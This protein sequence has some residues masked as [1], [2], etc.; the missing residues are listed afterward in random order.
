[1]L[2]SYKWAQRCA[3]ITWLLH[4]DDFLLL[5]FSLSLVM[6]LVC[7]LKYLSFL[8]YSSFK[9]ALLQECTIF[10]NSKNSHKI[11][12]ISTLRWLVI[13]SRG[14]IYSQKDSQPMGYQGAKLCWLYFLWIF[15]PFYNKST[16][17]RFGQPT[18]QIE[19]A[20]GFICLLKHQK[21]FFKSF[22]NI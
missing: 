3:N 18:C 12:N 11:L 13:G 15:S 19:K 1:M 2:F 21:M 9:G 20:H 7:A 6:S 22:L 17:L 16:C 5:Y 4:V 14:I 10:L 8:D